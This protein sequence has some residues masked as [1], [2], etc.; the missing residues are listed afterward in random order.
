M[1]RIQPVNYID[2]IEAIQSIRRQ[3]FQME[4]G[5][6]PELEF[7]RED[8]TATHFLVYHGENAIGTARIR[9]LES[10]NEHDP[11]IAKIERVSVLADYRGQGIG[12][13]LMEVAIA[14]LRHRG[15]THIKLNAQL[16]VQAFYKRLGFSPCGPVFEEAGMAH[17]AMRYFP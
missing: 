13:Q 12:Q 4:Q 14:H 2:N 9:Y 7:D 5:V 1:V 17:I 8:E 3:V 16:Q 6:P 11:L 15:I 10:D